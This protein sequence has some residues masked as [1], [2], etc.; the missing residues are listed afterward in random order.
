[1]GKFLS[2]DGHILC[3]FS[4]LTMAKKILVVDDDDRALKSLG[5]FLTNEGYEVEGASNGGEALELLENEKFDLVLS[6]VFMP[7]V[8]GNQFLGEVRSKF[9]STPV[10]LMSGSFTLASP[11]IFYSQADGYVLKPIDLEKLL[12]KIKEITV[13]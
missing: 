11:T 9:T 6:D 4:P 1:M 13:T 2:V 3:F 5:R 8:D 10:I 12:Q 7:V